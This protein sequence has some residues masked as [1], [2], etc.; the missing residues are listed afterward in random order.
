MYARD[1]LI[2]RIKKRQQKDVSS[3]ENETLILIFFLVAQKKRKRL[4]YNDKLVRAYLRASI[5]LDIKT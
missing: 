3:A 2:E 5:I 4:W 1:C